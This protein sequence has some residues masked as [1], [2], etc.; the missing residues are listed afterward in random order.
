LADYF[1]VSILIIHPLDVVRTRLQTDGR[2]NSSSRSSSGQ[3]R[4][5]IHCGRSILLEEGWRG[6]YRGIVPPLAAQAVYKG[7]IFG[8]NGISTRTLLSWKDPSSQQR[9]SIFDSFLCGMFAGTINSA[10][11]APVELVRNRLI[12]QSNAVKKGGDHNSYSGA[13]DCV[14]KVVRNEGFFGLWRGLSATVLRD[15]PGVGAWFAAFETVKRAIGESGFRKESDPI[16]VIISG[17]CGGIAFWTVA[18]PMDALKSVIQTTRTSLGDREPNVRDIIARTLKDRGFLGL[19]RTLY[20]GYDVALARGIPA[21]AIV[22]LVSQQATIY[23]RS[24]LNV[25]VA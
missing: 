8:A 10:V 9:L 12:V 13:V 24:T 7:V 1:I 3:Y 4:S 2:L 17:S 15:G 23:L 5:A 16:A 19:I 25:I 21:S 14:R 6:F 11:V 22:F 20:R 18:L